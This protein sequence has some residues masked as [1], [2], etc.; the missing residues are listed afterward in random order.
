MRGHHKKTL[1]KKVYEFSALC[2]ADV[3]LGIRIQETGQIFTL[4]VDTLGIW[5]SFRSQLVIYIYGLIG[6][7]S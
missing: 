3:C 4:C 5:S 6:F 2:D 7:Q 1:E